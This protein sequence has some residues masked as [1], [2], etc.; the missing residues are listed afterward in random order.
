MY[1]IA[2]LNVLRRRRAATK[3]SVHLL[4]HIMP[5]L[6]FYLHMSNIFCNFAPVISSQ[7]TAGGSI[8]L[9]VT[10]DIADIGDS[11]ESQKA[12]I[13]ACFGLTK[14]CKNFITQNK[15][16]VNVFCWY[17]YFISQ[18]CV[19]ISQRGDITAYSCDKGLAGTSL[20]RIGRDKVPRFFCCIIT[21]SDVL[22][23]TLHQQQTQWSLLLLICLMASFY[24]Y[25]RVFFLLCL[26]YLLSML[27]TLIAINV[28]S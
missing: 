2:A 26:F 6:Y 11:N 10:K 17:V 20:R 5:S 25:L 1:Q 13:D 21:N 28:F 7:G 23:P 9:I 14:S 15:M 3:S 22:E 4:R 19:Y 27:P 16:A 12:F 24:P 8:R 18:W